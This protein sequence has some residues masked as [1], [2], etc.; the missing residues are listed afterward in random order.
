MNERLNEAASYAL[1]EKYGI[2]VPAHRLARDRAG[3]VTAARAVGYPVVVKVVSPEIVHKSDVGGVVTGV[4]DE[5]GVMA[6]Y[7][8]VRT[9]AAAVPDA[10]FEG[11]IVEEHL[12][13]GQEFLIGGTT[14]PAFGKVLTVG[15]GGTLVELLRDVSFRVLPID[16]AGAQ[17]MVRELRSYALVKGY[18]GAPPLDEEALIGAV[19]AAARLFEHEAIVEFDINPLVLYADGAV[20]VDAGVVTSTPEVTQMFETAPFT[21]PEP[22]TIAV[23]GASTD[24]AKVGYA[25]MRN[26]LG[27]DG[28]LCPV[29]PHREQVLG[30]QAYPTVRAIRGEVDLAVVAVRAPLVPGVIEACGEKGVPLAVVISAGFGETGEAGQRLEDETRAMARKYGM[31]LLGPN[32][33]GLMLPHLG[34]NATFD[35]IAPKKGHLGFL[36]QSGAVITTIVDWSVMTETGFSAV[37]SVGNQADLGFADLLPAVAAA[38]ETRAAILYVEEVKD[39]RRFLE[40][41]RQVTGTVPVIAVKSGSSAKGRAAA[42]SHTGSLAG[43]FEVYSAAFR[44]AGILHAGSIEEAFQ[45]GELLASEGYPQGE[46]AYVIS[47]AG[48]FAVLASDFAERHGVSLQ[49]IPDDILRDLDAVL[50][51][52]WNRAN[53][54]D[55]VGDGGAGRYARVFDVMIE[56]QDAWDIAF[57]VTVPSAVLNPIEIAHEIVR[58]SRKTGKMVVPCLLGGET[59]QGAV[60]VLK[61]HCIPNFPEIEDAFRAVGTVLRSGRRGSGGRPACDRHGE[62]AR[63][64]TAPLPPPPR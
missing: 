41:A 63:F 49:T 54:M 58:F 33:L 55:I 30:L 50:P 14:D 15:T 29:N 39:G 27:F 28:R 60:R 32:C 4:V 10:H 20:A 57:V 51:S 62:R 23:V 3:A 44:Q 2:G 36:S 16:E 25:V 26:L 21:L 24:P 11:A 40:A 64:R 7:E 18:R 53:P 9:A 61:N 47:G 5:I 59:M 42:S 8:Q 12:P 17:A 6:A 19:L 35:P 13:H 38:P 43:S 45:L 1:L 22:R 46:R 48:G 37:V 31:R 56:H 52:L 34:I